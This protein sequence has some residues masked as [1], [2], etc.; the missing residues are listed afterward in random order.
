MICKLWQDIADFEEGEV[1]GWTHAEPNQQE[2]RACARMETYV[3]LF[4]R[5]IFND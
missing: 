5:M 1:R 2:A 4:E 3:R